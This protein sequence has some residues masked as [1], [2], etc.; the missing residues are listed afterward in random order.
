MKRLLAAALTLAPLPACAPQPA[1]FEVSSKTEAIEADAPPIGAQDVDASQISKD[2]QG[3]TP[4]TRHIREQDAPNTTEPTLYISP[5][6]PADGV[7]ATLDCI[8]WIESRGDY[9]AVSA[10]GKY[11]GGFQFDDATWRS[12]GGS[13]DPAE[14]SPEEQDARAAYLLE[15]RGLRPWPAAQGRC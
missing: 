14:A 11:R 10:D 12:V 5:P 2:S 8:R 7:Q 4:T 9:R 6:A 15:M 13:G 3:E 1:K